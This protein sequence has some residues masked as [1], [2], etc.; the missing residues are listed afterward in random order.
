MHNSATCKLKDPEHNPSH[1]C[2]LEFLASEFLSAEWW[3]TLDTEI[4]LPREKKRMVA[5]FQS[6]GKGH[7][8]RI[9]SP[10][11]CCCISTHFCPIWRI[12]YAFHK[13]WIFRAKIIRYTNPLT[14]I[15]NGKTPTVN[16]IITLFSRCSI[17]EFFRHCGKGFSC[18]S[19]RQSVVS[20][21][22]KR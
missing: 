3:I 20:S 8:K 1:F 4:R 18:L 14:E 17:L 2:Q 10:A 6:L 21:C 9:F 11:N 22:V 16:V 7:Q 13:A 19:V 5:R 15:P 12:K